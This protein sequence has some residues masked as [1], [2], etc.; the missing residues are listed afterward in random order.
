MILIKNL[1]LI[2][3]NILHSNLKIIYIIK[4]IKSISDVITTYVNTINI[5]KLRILHEKSLKW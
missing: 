4:W 3:L 2:I 1:L 5:N